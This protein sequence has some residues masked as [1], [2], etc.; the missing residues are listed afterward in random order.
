M[1]IELFLN[2]TGLYDRPPLLGVHFE[3][4]VQML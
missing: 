3:H 1:K 4:A 2:N